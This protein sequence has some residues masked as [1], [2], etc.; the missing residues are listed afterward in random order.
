MSITDTRTAFEAGMLRRALFTIDAA[1]TTM[2]PT[3]QDG[4]SRC[5]LTTV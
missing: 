2:D 4:R 5:A 3:C 1:S